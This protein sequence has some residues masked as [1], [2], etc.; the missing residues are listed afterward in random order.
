MAV[1]RSFITIFFITAVQIPRLATSLVAFLSIV[2]K[3]NINLNQK[4]VRQ[5]NK[6][7]FR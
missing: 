4:N 5:L 7:E 2:P 1:I 6:Y 3:E